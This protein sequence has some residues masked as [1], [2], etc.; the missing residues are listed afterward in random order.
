MNQADPFGGA[1]GGARGGADPFGDPGGSNP[2]AEDAPKPESQRRP[3]PTPQPEPVNP[4]A[5][6]PTPAATS[7]VPER[8]S[9]QPGPAEPDDS[10][11]FGGVPE[12]PAATDKPRGDG[13][14][15]DMPFDPYEPEA[16]GSQADQPQPNGPQPD[17][18]QPAA[19][20]F[21]GP[22]GP[23]PAADAGSQPMTEDEPVAGSNAGLMLPVPAA[24]AVLP[25]AFGAADAPAAKP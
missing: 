8:A 12:S 16:D 22:F 6:F 5:E 18:P 14:S 11:F 17:G 4:P 13:P 19:S 23:P 20:P 25:D 10:V 9:G 2:F 1:D 7:L 3:E 24:D 21:G 15:V